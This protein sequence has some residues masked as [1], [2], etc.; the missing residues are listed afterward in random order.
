MPIA[1]AINPAVPVTELTE[2][3]SIRVYR[4]FFQEIRRI[5]YVEGR[6][7]IV[8]RYSGQEQTERLTT[9]RYCELA[10]V[11]TYTKIYWLA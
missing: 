5:G 10:A 11:K 3:S 2:T 9:S 4:A 6:N 7:P 8:E 1:T